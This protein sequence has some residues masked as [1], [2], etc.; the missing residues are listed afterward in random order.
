MEDASAKDLDWFFRGW[1]FTTQ[2]VDIALKNVDWYQISSQNPEEVTPSAKKADQERRESLTGRRNRKEIQETVVESRYEQLAD[3]YT[4]YDRTDVTEQER[5]QYQ[6]LLERLNKEQQQ[7]LET[8]LNLY[9]VDFKNK[10]G[11]VMPLILRFQFEDGSEEI[12][13]IPAALWR[14]NND[15][16][17]KVFRFE[18]KVTSIELDPYKETTDTNR[19]N[20]YYSGPWKKTPLKVKP[21][22]QDKGKNL[23][24]QVE[25]NQ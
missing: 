5:K 24:Q 2:H 20:N 11:L 21:K 10:G 4:K 8:Q 7:L 25:G 13:R 6:D 18:K 17:S 22:S 12:K 14:K 19:N 3:F 1:F 16:V 15:H 23:M 9:Q